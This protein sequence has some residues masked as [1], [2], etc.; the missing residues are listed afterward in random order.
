MWD[1]LLLHDNEKTSSNR[2]NHAFASQS[3]ELQVCIAEFKQLNVF[4]LNQS[5][6]ST[7]CRILYK[8]SRR[9]QGEEYNRKNKT[10]ALQYSTGRRIFGVWLG[11]E[12]HQR[13]TVDYQMLQLVA[14]LFVSNH[15]T[16]NKKKLERNPFLL[17]CATEKTCYVVP[18]LLL[19][20]ALFFCSFA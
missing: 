18:P 6:Q 1:P 3:E 12:S 4:V 8:I 15:T 19:P 14:A 5:D 17:A 7:K 13:R 9:I 2:R 20:M 11:R 10:C 16:R